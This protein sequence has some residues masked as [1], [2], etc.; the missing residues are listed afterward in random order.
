[1]IPALYNFSGEI[2][3]FP[4]FMNFQGFCE[5]RSLPAECQ[6][7][8]VRS[9]GSHGNARSAYNRKIVGMGRDKY[10][11]IVSFVSNMVRCLKRNILMQHR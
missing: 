4:C 10:A 5:D 7:R 9:N 1:M 3:W 11:F 8:V 6:H 2:N